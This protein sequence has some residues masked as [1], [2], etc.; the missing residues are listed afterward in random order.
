[1][2]HLRN[3]TLFTRPDLS[4]SLNTYVLEYFVLEMHN[5]TFSQVRER[6]A[7]PQYKTS[8]IN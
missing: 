2:F 8:Y 5:F 3:I 4:S 7:I 1:M 6:K